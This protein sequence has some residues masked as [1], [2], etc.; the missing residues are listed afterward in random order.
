M[1]ERASSFDVTLPIQVALPPSVQ[2][3]RGDRPAELHR[4]RRRRAGSLAVR[5]INKIP[6]RRATALGCARGRRQLEALQ[7]DAKRR[8]RV[9]APLAALA[10]V[11]CRAT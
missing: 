7:S 9:G 5:P 11:L 1:P 4:L 8:D 3:L 2:L 10:V 6:L